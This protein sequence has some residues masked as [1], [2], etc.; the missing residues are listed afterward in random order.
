MKSGFDRFLPMSPA[1]LHILLA[2]ASRDMHGY[3]A[4]CRRLLVRARARTS[5]VP[6][7]S[8]TI[9][10]DSWIRG[11]WKSGTTRIAKTPVAVTIA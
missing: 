9:S 5:S 2:L 1:T 11:S 4:S 3:G 6:E 10:S 7:L 8:M